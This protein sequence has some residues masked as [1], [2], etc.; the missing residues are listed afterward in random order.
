MALIVIHDGKRQI[1]DVVRD[2][3]AE[4]DHQKDGT[5]QGEAQPDAVAQKLDRFADRVGTKSLPA[6][7]VPPCRCRFGR[8]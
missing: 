8:R 7:G 1:V 2:A 5:E 6:E 3:E 4:H